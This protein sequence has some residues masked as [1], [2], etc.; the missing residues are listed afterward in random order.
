MV[1]AAV[2]STHVTFPLSAQ[3]TDNT[4]L[5][6]HQV[7]GGIGFSNSGILSEIVNFFQVIEGVD[8]DQNPVIGG[9]YLFQ[10]IRRIAVGGTIAHQHFSVTYQDPDDSDA[11]SFGLTANRFYLGT[12]GLFYLV[13]QPHFRMYSG[14]RIGFSNW[15]VKSDIGFPSDVIDQVIN[16][17]LGAAFAPQLIILGGETYLT[18]HWGFGGELAIG[19][20]H[21]LGFG[22]SYRW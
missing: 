1:L 5:Y 15:N 21:L 3:E 19:A 18:K 16:F 8:I 13:D 7:R 14:A 20:P 2:A 11:R 4:V 12:V 17:A 22:L 6:Q 10:S 9:T